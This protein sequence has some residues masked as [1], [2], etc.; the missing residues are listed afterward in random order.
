MSDKYE[1]PHLSEIFQTLQSGKHICYQD[2][3]LFFTL[4][5]KP[6]DYMAIFKALGFELVTHPKD[7]YYFRMKGKANTDSTKQI[8]LFIFLLIE[9]LDR[10]ENDLESALMDNRFYLNTL[11]HLKTERYRELMREV[12]ITDEEGL[13]SVIANMQKYG[14]AVTYGR[15][16]FE[17]R[18]PVYR[19][20]DLCAE[21]ITAQHEEVGMGAQ[22]D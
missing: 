18:S 17:F 21:E 13:V 5:E 11:P 6:D 8:A 14:I 19:F 2:G 10:R 9:H 1:L 22:N 4:Q 7:F 16:S 12:K 20:F 3:A 15:L